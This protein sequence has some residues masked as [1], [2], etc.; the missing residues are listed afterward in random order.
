MTCREMGGTCDESMTSNTPEEMMEHGNA[1]VA[2]SHP[3]ILE[4]MKAMSTEEVDAWKAEFM[5][6]WEATPDSQ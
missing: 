2:A 4:Q 3:E 5:K 6:K 1:H